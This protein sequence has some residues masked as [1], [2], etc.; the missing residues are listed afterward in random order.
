MA[1]DS[2]RTFKSSLSPR[3]KLPNQACHIHW[4][5][6]SFDPV[7]DQSSN[8]QLDTSVLTLFS[9]FHP[10]SW[11]FG[12]TGWSGPWKTQVGIARTQIPLHGGNFKS[13]SL[14]GSVFF[15]NL[16]H[17]MERQKVNTF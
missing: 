1:A 4:P 7:I 17:K 12:L 8:W 16:P 9:L 10:P 15:D 13:W 2:E 6:T 11:P 5:G 14:P 3:S